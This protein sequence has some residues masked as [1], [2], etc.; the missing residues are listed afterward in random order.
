VKK[1]ESE[2]IRIRTEVDTYNWRGD[3]IHL[4][5]VPALKNPKTGK[6]R[7]YPADV[8]KA[9]FATY[10]AEYGLEPRDIATLLMLCAK[11]GP[12]PAGIQPLRYRLNKSL[13][14]QWKEMDAKLL[15]ETFPR[16][17]FIP[18]K[19]G[20]IPK[21]L[22]SDLER[23]EKLGLVKLQWKKWGEGEMEKSMTIT[24]TNKAF[25]VSKTLWKK[26]PTP[27]VEVTLKVKE[28]IFPLD[29]KTIRNRVHREYP[30]YQKTYTDL[31]RD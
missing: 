6:V 12:F 5:D 24:L 21:N 30:E 9:E 18:E 22:N 3:P 15:G 28:R 29:P 10:A 27:F 31:D 25:D 1:M 26:V 20:P 7:I 8:A 4:K 19:R 14:Y 17:E 13:F 2:W 16:D 11:P 23:L